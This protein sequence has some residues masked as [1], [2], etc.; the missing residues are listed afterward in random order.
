[1]KKRKVN[2]L[3]EKKGISPLIATVLLIGFTI[4][5][6]ALVMKWGGELFRTTTT[7]QGCM[8]EARLTCASDIEIDISAENTTD[9]VFTDGLNLNVN[10]ISKTNR[11]ID[12]FWVILYRNDGTTR[13]ETAEYEDT[14]EAFQTFTQTVILPT[15]PPADWDTEVAR[16]EVIPKIDYQQS[17]GTQCP[18]ECSEKS[19]MFE[20]T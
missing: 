19:E 9:T 1:M 20:F 10:I 13:E 3:K 4:V 7:T 6:A 11:Q 15:D 2:N 17:D 5:L 18:T 8:A 12:G 14:I 16:V